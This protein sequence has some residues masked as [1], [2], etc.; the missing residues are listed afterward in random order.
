MLLATDI[1]ILSFDAYSYFEK[2]LLYAEPLK[3]FID[4][5]GILAWGLVPTS[6]SEHIQN[7]TK[8]SLTERWESHMERLRQKG[9]DPTGTIEQS[10]ITPSCGAG[11]LSPDDALRVLLLLQEVSGEL[12]RRYFTKTTPP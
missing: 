11:S 1:D 9:F 5:G 3:A 12:R 7:E 2:V 8:D 4:R 10:L 6:H